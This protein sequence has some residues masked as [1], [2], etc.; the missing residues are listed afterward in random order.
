VGNE[1]NSKI[2][3][4]LESQHDWPCRYTF[5]FIVPRAEYDKLRT[6]VPLGEISERPSASGKYVS[7]TLIAHMKTP[8]DVLKVYDEVSKIEKIVCL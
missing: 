6:L 5:K 8:D 2:K 1:N 7:V 4:L 3:D